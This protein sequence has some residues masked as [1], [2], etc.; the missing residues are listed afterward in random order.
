[1]FVSQEK[2]K[3]A[4]TK[5][6]EVATLGGG[7]FWC[8]EAVFTQL[9]GVEKVESGYSGG[10]LESPTYEQVST[11]TTGHAEAVQITFDPNV[12]SYKEILEIFFSTHDPTTLNRQGP[13]VGTQYRSVIFYH[14]DQ[15]KAIAEQVIKEITEEKVFDAPIVTQ[16]EP[17]RVFY[18]AEDY[19]RDYFKRHPE[20]PYCSLVIAPKLAKL[21]ELYISKLKLQV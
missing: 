14:T 10:K 3:P 6:I 9:K 5:Q 8:T 19:H 21:R 20:Q 18:E 2:L 4:A 11:G 17:F 1:M 16:L 15:Q 7:C 13:D 12:I